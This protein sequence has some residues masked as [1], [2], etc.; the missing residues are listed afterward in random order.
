MS[1]RATDYAD[2][3]ADEVEVAMGTTPLPVAE[4]VVL[5]LADE[6]LVEFTTDA[7]DWVPAAATVGGAARVSMSHSQ[8]VRAFLPRFFFPS[9]DPAV[10][11]VARNRTIFSLWFEDHEWA[12]MLTVLKRAGL[13]RACEDLGPKTLTAFDQILLDLPVEDEDGLMLTA[14]GWAA[15]EPF[16]EPARVMQQQAQNQQAPQRRNGRRC[17]APPAQRQL[18]QIQTPARAGP[19]ELRYL[20]CARLSMLQLPEVRAPFRVICYLSGMLGSCLTHATRGDEAAQVR[21]VGEMLKDAL[22]TRYNTHSDVGLAA[23]LRALLMTATLPALLAAPSIDEA[24][25]MDEARDAFAFHRS[26]QG[27]L[28]VTI[29]RLTLVAPR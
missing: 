22:Q 7:L 28:D 2:P 10:M 14:G 4:P 21:L 9:S 23:N 18:R 26:A 13:A 29:S 8:M 6:P 27:R 17:D 12:R 15:G 1:A 25:L 3:N 19:A 5:L 11:V 24:S 16:D 20:H